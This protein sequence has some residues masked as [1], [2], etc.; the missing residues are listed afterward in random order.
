MILIGRNNSPFVRRV[1]ASLKLLGLPFEQ[2]QLSTVTNREDVERVN[3]LGR[4]PALVL[5]NDEVLIDSTA[6]L[7]C[8][9]ELAGPEKA[10]VP[11][12]GPDRRRVLKLVA[13][14]MGVMEKSLGCYVERQVRPGDKLHQALLDRFAAQAQAG[15]AALENECPADGWLFGGKISQ[16]DV[17]A[18]AGMDF[19]RA[20]W[21]EQLPLNK[22]PR[23]EALRTRAYA[24]PAIAETKP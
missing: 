5:D 20:F 17:S 1:A 15:L 4:I 10:L 6:I 12:S 19:I 16:A 9:D 7:D 13:L 21:P 2:Q 18:V 14:A 11:A 24:L 3:P 23:L 22:Y 8:L